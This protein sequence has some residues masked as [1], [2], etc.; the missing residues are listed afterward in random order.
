M[1]TYRKFCSPECRKVYG[2][3]RQPD[4]TN[5]VTF[6]CQNQSCG[7]EV[8]RY[9]RYG[10]GAN[11][12]CSNACAQRHTR[13]KAHVVMSDDDVVLD[14]KWEALFWGLM[15]FYKVPCERYDRERAVE[16]SEGCWYAPDFYL[17]EMD[18]AVEIKGQEDP[19]D[20][21]RW[22]LYRTER[23]RL[24]VLDRSGLDQLVHSEDKARWLRGG[25]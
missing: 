7:K 8:T 21:V 1:H 11:M 4:P 15:G 12:F 2:K 17:P 6:I 23:G 16:W 10:N 24:L 18:T 14:S 22:D 3:K 19:D 9:K 20:A 5:Y 25:A 13:T